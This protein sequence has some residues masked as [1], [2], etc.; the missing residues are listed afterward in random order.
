MKLAFVIL[1]CF[2]TLASAQIETKVHC[3]NINYCYTPCRELCLKPH[4]CINKR[5][6]CNPKINVCT[7]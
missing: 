4:K 3:E 2:L 1:L 5:C 7:R 6:T